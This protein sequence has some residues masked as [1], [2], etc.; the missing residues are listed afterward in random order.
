MSGG[1]EADQRGRI[2]RP[3]GRRPAVVGIAVAAVVLTVAG[4]SHGLPLGPAP[5]PAPV[6]RHLA[7]A[8]VLQIVRS[9]P[10]SPA[11]S[12]PAGSAK[13]PDP[14]DNFPGSDQCYRK[15]GTPL[16]ITSAAVVQGQ[17]GP[18]SYGLRIMLPAAQAAALRATTRQAYQ[19]RDQIAV[20]IAG[21]TW[22]APYVTAPFG[23]GFA[24]PAQ[25]ANQARRLLRT[26]IPST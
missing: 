3:S 13:L 17:T 20:I 15:T 24:V 26:L 6:P 5:I 19:S 8:I 18:A 16:T 25:S 11:G 22:S 14:A 1:P 23:G 12:C 4:C 10:S 2:V 7:T 9:Q 21:K